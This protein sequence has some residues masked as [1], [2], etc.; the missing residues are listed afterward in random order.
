[1]LYIRYITHI[2]Y[3]G[4]VIYWQATKGGVPVATKDDWK[5]TQPLQTDI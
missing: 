4:I 3:I 2:K 1:M 5:I